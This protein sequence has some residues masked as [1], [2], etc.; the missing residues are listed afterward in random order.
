MSRKKL[1]AWVGLI[2]VG[3]HAFILLLV[4]LAPAL[5]GTDQK[6]VFAILA[7]IAP[8]FAGYATAIIKYYFSDKATLPDA[9]MVSFP[10]WLSE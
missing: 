5:F 9:E 3:F 7:V 2:V 6:D 8:L 1:Q 10:G 4:F